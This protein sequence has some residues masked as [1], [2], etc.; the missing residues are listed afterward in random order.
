LKV[1]N[2][3]GKDSGFDLTYGAAGPRG[4][5]GAGG[6]Q[7]AQGLDGPVGAIGQQGPK[8]SAGK[9]G[10]VLSYVTFAQWNEVVLPFES[11]GTVSQIT[12][13]N[14]GVYV[15][16]GQQLIQNQNLNGGIYVSCSLSDDSGLYVQGLP[17]SLATMGSQ[18]AATLP[19]NG[20][21]VVQTAPKTI[22]VQCNYGP[23]ASDL[24]VS[25]S[26]PVTATGGTLTAI[27]V[28]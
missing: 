22:Y 10:G 4:P 28:K 3:D 14:P 16:N 25:L 24:N 12:L 11:G 7:G 26:Q 19:L 17:E 2:S 23:L 9:P 1:K 18:G 21:Y 15:L 6:P 8:G 27:Q 13:P 20:Y 5:A